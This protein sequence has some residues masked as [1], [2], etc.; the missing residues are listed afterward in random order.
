MERVTSTMLS[1][2]TQRYYTATV[3]VLPPSNGL[4]RAQRQPGAPKAPSFSTHRPLGHENKQ[5]NPSAFPSG[6]PEQPQ[7]P[8]NENPQL[9]TFSLEGLGI[10]KNMRRFI[11]AIACV[12]GTV[13]TYTYYLWL[14]RW[15]YGADEEERD[16][17]HK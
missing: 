11:I 12:L 15:Y 4:C 9:P 8:V 5:A 16:V 10:S 1:K 6:K 13:E 2:A 3:R 7:K 14:R 17:A